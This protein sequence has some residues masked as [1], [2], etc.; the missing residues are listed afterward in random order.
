MKRT[1]ILFALLFA[2]TC[3]FAQK[4]KVTSALS[5]KETGKLD[6]AV[7]AIEE[8]IDANNPKTEGSVTWPRTW[9]V[10]GEIY[11]AVFQSK[12]E[13]YKKLSADPLTVAFDSY[14]KALQLDDKDR[15][16][17]SVKIKLTLLIGD[18]TN[19]A[20]AAFNEENY[21]KAMKSFEQII[22]IE[23]TPVYKAEDP[24]AIDTVIIFNAGLAAYNAQKYDKAIEYY[25]QAA[26]YKYNG[27]KTYSLISS[28]YLQKQ[29][30]LGALNILQDGL[31]E[32]SD[33]GAL[34]VEVIN[35]YLNANKV[36]DAMKYLDIAISQDPKNS[37]YYFAQGTLYDKLQRT[38]DAANSYLKA[39]E[40]KADYFDAYYNLGALY[41]NKGVKQVDVANSIPSN[42]PEK[43]E[44][45]KNKAD[46]EFKKAI[47][48]MEKAHEV[49]PTDKFTME[50]LKTLYYRLKMLDKH[51]EIV[52]KMKNNQ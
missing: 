1:T 9:E 35:I 50:S 23:Q 46:I 24:N 29:D 5:Y 26:K 15:F 17:K 48:Y 3:A 37:S 19:Q 2:V 13:N 42:Q 14:M 45:E 31:K 28:S 4:G 25:K 16:G 12:D 47:P 6:K 32:Y 30:T 33:N 10:R 21:E 20:V 44:E 36:D 22:A 34:L 38:E 7:E 51:A 39:I 8:T 41:Y 52:E 40:F 43:Y 27:A 18:L 49:N 11:Q